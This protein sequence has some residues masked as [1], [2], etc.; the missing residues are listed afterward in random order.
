M[1]DTHILGIE[2][3]WYETTSATKT[4]KAVPANGMFY[5]RSDNFA[6]GEPKG[7]EVRILQVGS[8]FVW[9]DQPIA[10]DGVRKLADDGKLTITQGTEKAEYAVKKLSI[11]ELYTFYKPEFNE[12]NEACRVVFAPNHY[13]R[14]L[15]L[16]AEVFTSIGGESD[17]PAHAK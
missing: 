8:Q 10:F 1:I 11:Q 15:Y 4:G 3:P 12:F 5:K 13:W 16:W 2:K 6:E 7:K 17:Y 14:R 9:V